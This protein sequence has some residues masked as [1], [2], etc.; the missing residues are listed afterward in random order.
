MRTK[1]KPGIEWSWRRND[2]WGKARTKR[3]AILKAKEARSRE[4]SRLLSQVREHLDLVCG[5]DKVIAGE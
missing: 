2:H 5:F 3:Y 4:S 1:R